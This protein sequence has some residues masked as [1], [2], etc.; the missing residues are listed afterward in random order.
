MTKYYCDHLR[1]CRGSKRDIWSGPTISECWANVFD[2]GPA[3]SDRR[4]SVFSHRGVGIRRIS[5]R[6]SSDGSVGL[7]CCLSLTHLSTWGQQPVISPEQTAGP[8]L[9]TDHPPPPALY[10]HWYSLWVLHNNSKT[11]C[12]FK[13]ITSTYFTNWVNFGFWATSTKIID[14]MN[15]RQKAAINHCPALV[16]E[17]FQD[18]S[19]PEVSHF[20][21]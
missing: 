8:A 13:T 2:V 16:I 6:S 3:F 5:P 7:A 19:F 20:V 10:D 15:K 18:A 1:W 21:W 14:Q 4:A 9:T 17:I 12:S 11:E